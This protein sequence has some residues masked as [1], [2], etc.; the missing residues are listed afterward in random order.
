M[1]Y[2]NGVTFCLVKDSL[3]GGF[4]FNGKLA[5]FCE[6]RASNVCYARLLVQR[7]TAQ[8]SLSVLE[9]ISVLELVSFFIADWI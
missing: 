9:V 1:K 4:L 7:A 8:V 6:I 3:M 5:N 2:L